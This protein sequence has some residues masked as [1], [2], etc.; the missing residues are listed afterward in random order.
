MDSRLHLVPLIEL[1]RVLGER[2]TVGGSG[3][4]ME[5]VTFGH[6]RAHC[7]TIG[8]NE[9]LHVLDWCSEAILNLLKD[10]EVGALW[11]LSLG[12]SGRG[13]Q[14]LCKRSAHTLVLELL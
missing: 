8:F 14:S 1:E 12:K 3:V 11:E 5:T 4:T 7:I 13:T 6:L 10:R 2:G 9:A